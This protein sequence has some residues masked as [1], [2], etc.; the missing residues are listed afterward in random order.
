[1]VPAVEVQDLRVRLSGHD[2]L[3]GVGFSVE[4]GTVLA[5]LGP[6]GAG[7]T[8][9]VDVLTTRRPPTSGTAMVLGH[10]VVRERREVCRRIAVARQDST[11]DTFLTGRENLTTCARLLGSSRHDARRVADRLLERFD[12]VDASTRAVSGY[13]GGMRRRLDLA[14]CLVGNP[15]VI[16]L[17]E[18]TT[19]LDPTSRNELWEVLRELVA[20]GTTIVL[21][22][23]YL[24]EADA[25]ADAIV[26][27]SAGVVVADGTPAELKRAIG[28]SD[29]LE[30]TL[31]C[32]ADALSVSLR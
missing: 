22:T 2:V 1:M 18:P 15:A 27:V 28:G 13:S 20:T 31:G 5:L 9:T 21:T 11:V 3:R 24:D 23:Q 12:L 32:P 16:F 29:R 19:G 4:P 30:V 17:D 6:N 25:L 10:D 26:M 7:K 8:T 14:M